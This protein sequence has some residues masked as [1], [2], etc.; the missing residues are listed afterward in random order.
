[1]GGAHPK[2]IFN[3]FS[4]T[5][6]IQ[7]KH[8]RS[9]EKSTKSFRKFVQKQEIKPRIISLIKALRSDTTKLRSLT[10]FSSS[11]LKKVGTCDS[12]HKWNSPCLIPLLILNILEQSGCIVDYPR[13]L[14]WTSNFYC[15]SQMGGWYCLHWRNQNFF[16]FPNRKF[17]KIWKKHWKFYTFLK[18]FKEIMNLF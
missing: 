7:F 10:H 17:S 6:I 5:S 1:M 4:K 8:L 14:F 9:F 18:S 16:V 12:P 11:K 15:I 13:S 3:D 2:L